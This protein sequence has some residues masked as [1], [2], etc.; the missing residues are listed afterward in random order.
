MAEIDERQA[1]DGPRFDVRFRVNGQQRKKTFRKKGDAERYLNQ[2]RAEENDGLVTDPQG[3]E[4]LFG[5]YAREWLKHRLVKGE[6]LTPATRQGYEA[7]L[8]RNIYPHFEKTRLRQ[9][10]PDRVRSWYSTLTTDKSADQAAKSYR[11]LRAILNTAF[12]DRLIRFKPCTIKGAGIER[13]RERSLLETSDVLKLADAFTPRLRAMIMLGGF[14]GLRPGELLGL[15][16]QDID[17]M[18]GTVRVERQAQEITGRGRIITGPKSDAG[19]RTRKLPESVAE[20]L[21]EHLAAFVAPEPDAP[22][23]T[24]KS[25]LPLRRSDLSNEWKAACEKVGLKGFAP[26]DL[27]HHALTN[28]AGAPE[29]TLR[30]I[31]AEGGHSSPAAALRYQHTSEERGRGMAD[32]MDRLIR[33]ANHPPG[34]GIVRIRP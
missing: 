2:V 31:M 34:A 19:K 20:S 5:S 1:R 17:L 16:R 3:G 27:R 25:G 12:S 22:V 14:K 9:M 33:A 24:R 6:P 15:Q 32:Y 28:V 18:H 8:R 4:R 13:A 23:F 7:L 26:Y 21:K 30:E 10:T 11:L 29:A